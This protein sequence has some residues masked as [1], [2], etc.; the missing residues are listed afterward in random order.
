MK[1]IISILILIFICQNLY[2]FA[3]VNERAYIEKGHAFLQK[4]VSNQ[5]P[6]LN[7][8][9]I[10]KAKYFYYIASQNLP[11]S[12]EALTG[13]GRVYSMQDK[14]KEA[15]NTFFKAYSIDPYNANTSF[16][17]GEFLYKY[18]EYAEALKYFEIAQKLGFENAS[19]NNEMI[20]ICKLKLGVITE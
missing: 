5:N 6:E 9:Y 16:Y 19:K 1:K 17:F 8:I 10:N 15:K 18:S 3:N 4:A 12:S 20:N 13:L 2:T 11:P 14:Y 7:L